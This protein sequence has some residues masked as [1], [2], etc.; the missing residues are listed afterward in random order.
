VLKNPVV[1]SIFALVGRAAEVFL[2]V[3]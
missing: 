2:L 1:G 3:S